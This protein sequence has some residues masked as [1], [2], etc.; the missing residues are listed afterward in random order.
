MGTAKKCRICSD[1][2]DSSGYCVVIT[3]LKHYNIDYTRL[4]EVS[5]QALYTDSELEKSF[6]QYHYTNLEDHAINSRWDYY[7]WLNVHKHT[8]NALEGYL[9]DKIKAD[10]GEDVRGYLMQ[11]W[12]FLPMH[13]SGRGVSEDQQRHHVDRMIASTTIEERKA[14]DRFL[15]DLCRMT[16]QDTLRRRIALEWSDR[17]FGGEFL[18]A[19]RLALFKRLLLQT[20]LVFWPA[21]FVPDISI[22]SNHH[23]E[24]HHSELITSNTVKTHGSWL[25]INCTNQNNGYEVLFLWEQLLRPRDISFLR[26][27]VIVG[28]ERWIKAAMSIGLRTLPNELLLEIIRF[29]PEEC[30]MHFAHT[31]KAHLNISADFLL[32]RASTAASM[33]RA[34]YAIRNVSGCL[35]AKELIYEFRK[36]V[37]ARIITAFESGQLPNARLFLQVLQTNGLSKDPTV[38]LMPTKCRI[39][40][41]HVFELGSDKSRSCMAIATLKYLGIDHTPLGDGSRKASYDGPELEGRFPLRRYEYL[42]SSAV[43]SSEIYDIYEKGT[44]WSMRY[45]DEGLVRYYEWGMVHKHTFYALEEYLKNELGMGNVHD[46]LIR[47]W[48]FLPMHLSGRGLSKKCQ[49][50]QVACM[51]QYTTIEERKAT[52]KFLLELCVKAIQ[53]AHTIFEDRKAVYDFPSD[54]CEG[55]PRHMRQTRTTLEYPAGFS[56]TQYLFQFAT[57]LLSRLLL[58]TPLMFWPAVLIPGISKKFEN[59]NML[60]T[61]AQIRDN[62]SELHMECTRCK[63]QKSTTFISTVIYLIPHLA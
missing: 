60:T 24:Y 22:S 26:E 35:G 18:Q 23:S 14:I 11:L 59:E 29:I 12:P 30:I 33:T 45:P 4:A 48:L 25:Y 52:D 38:S 58:Q 16:P 57:R 42:E 1:E 6:P 5:S 20:P 32:K 36:R 40:S 49:R 50:K 44:E 28:S 43:D 8:L 19:F 21:I 9:Q 15:T 46:H 7:K 47:L 10:R 54:L 61:S 27:D 55:V 37:H 62:S 41:G 3:T 31:S 17:N 63:I 51:L 13:L 34:S 56:K 2:I 53:H 39:C